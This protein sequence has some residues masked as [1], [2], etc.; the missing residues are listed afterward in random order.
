MSIVCLCSAAWPSTPAWWPTATTNATCAP[1]ATPPHWRARSKA[2]SNR[3]WARPWPSTSAR[4]TA[5][6]VALGSDPKA[7][8]AAV[9]R[10]EV[11]GQGLAQA[12]FDR[13]FD[14]ARQCGGVARGAQVA[15]VVAVGHHAGVDGHAAEHKQT[16]DIGQRQLLDIGQD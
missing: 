6:S 13:A 10:A 14:L 11:L 2:R 8:L 4:S 1:R 5:A 15:F 12:L 9:D 16:I 7:T 3:A